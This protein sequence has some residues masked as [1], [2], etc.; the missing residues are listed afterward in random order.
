MFSNEF[1]VAQTP[2]YTPGHQTY[3]TAENTPTDNRQFCWELSQWA[4]GR[5]G[6]LRFRNVTHQHAD[7]RPPESLVQSIHSPSA[8][9]SD[10]SPLTHFPEP[11]LSPHS[12]VYRIND[13]IVFSM[14]VEELK[15]SEVQQ[16]QEWTPFAPADLQMEFV[17]LDVYVR[18]NMTCD[19]TTGLCRVQFKAPDVYGIFKFRVMYR[20]LGY[21]VLHTENE[22]AIRPYRQN[23]YERF[24]ATAAPYYTSTIT[25]LCAVIIFI[26]AW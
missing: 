17:M 19:P 9:E 4:F 15:S 22:I 11:E 7:S 26:I 3:T 23:E 16:Q 2:I 8:E 18:K 6:V 25:T 1:F 24:L 20:R 12:Q 10:A 13:E 21:S 5:S 14:I